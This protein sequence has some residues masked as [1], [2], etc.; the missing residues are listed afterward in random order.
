[1]CSRS[2]AL[3]IRQLETWPPR[4]KTKQ[5]PRAALRTTIEYAREIYDRL[6]A[7]YPTHC[8]LDF[9]SPFQLI[10]A[11]ILSAQ[12]RQAREH[13]PPA[14]FKNTRPR[15]RPRRN[16]RS[17]SHGL[18]PEQGKE[19]LGMSAAVAGQHGGKV[20]AMD[21]GELPG[22]GRKTAGRAGN[23][24][25]R[26]EAWWSSTSHAWADDKPHENVDPVKIGKT[27]CSSFRASAG[28]CFR[29]CSFS[30]ARNL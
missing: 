21:A 25:T 27:W 23:A 4:K 14:L 12:C 22:V 17:S 26:T 28:R 13:G 15:W 20:P 16:R 24:F 9:N 3:V 2:P 5:I 29:I 8:A 6:I 1:M 7:N 10:V 19:P 11:T 30:T 18:L